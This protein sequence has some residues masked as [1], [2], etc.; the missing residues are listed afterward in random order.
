MYLHIAAS[1]KLMRHVAAETPKRIQKSSFS[2]RKE[3]T[4]SYFVFV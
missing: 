2:W 4:S 1:S 3:I